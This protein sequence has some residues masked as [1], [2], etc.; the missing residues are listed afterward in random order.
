VT[1]VSAFTATASRAVIERIKAL[2]FN[3]AD[4]RLVAGSAD[5]PG[6]HYAVQPVLSRG[7]A[8]LEMAREAERPLLIFCRT[9][10]DTEV[11]A[12]AIRRGAPDR[13]VAFYHAGLT[14]EERS[15]V[16]KWFLDSRDGALVA[17]CAY[18]LG[19]DKPDIRSVVH[20]DIPSSVESY[21]QESGRAGRD[22]KPS[23]SILFLSRDEELFRARL[24]DSVARQRYERLLAYAKQSGNCRRSHLLSLI[25]QDPVAC[26]GCDVC[27]GRVV[28]TPAGQ[29]EILW[30]ARRHRRR[31][32]IGQAAEILSGARG[33]LAVRAFHDCVPGYA[34]MR[35]W[36][37]EEVEIAIRS[38]V[39]AGSLSVPAR[40]LWKGRLIYNRKDAGPHHT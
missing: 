8:L 17:T 11:A 33:P 39:A 5:R 23:R 4:V 16:E 7:H 1:M 24:Q 38:L 14:R 36:E 30:F 37:K 18:G 3:D 19:V 26:A 31:F 6:I 12:R 22:G 20:T 21:L 10:N 2:L 35:S 40:G 28:T 27:E 15:G 13:P 34:S 9:R 29:A 32:S 25:G